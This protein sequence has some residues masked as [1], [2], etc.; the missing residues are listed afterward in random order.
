MEFN[1]LHDLIFACAKLLL[2]VVVSSEPDHLFVIVC[3]IQCI[4][5][6]TLEGRVEIASFSWIRN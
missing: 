4:R 2:R 6:F 1:N 3:Q 5:R